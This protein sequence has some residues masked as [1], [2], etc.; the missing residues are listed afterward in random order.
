V[1]ASPP[2]PTAA[3][4]ARSSR[5]SFRALT[6]LTR[7]LSSRHGCAALEDIERRGVAAVLGED[8]TGEGPPE[9]LRGILLPLVPPNG[10]DGVH[11]LAWSFSDRAMWARCGL[12]IFELGAARSPTPS[13]FTS[14]TPCSCGSSPPGGQA[15][16]EGGSIRAA[17]ATLT[18]PIVRVRL[19][20]QSGARALPARLELATGE[21]RDFERLFA[22]AGSAR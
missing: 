11:A 14:S 20:V 6:T 12:S 3:P 10:V 8:G 13:P 21:R 19:R 7:L 9:L 5:S 18:R 22:V 16:D 2:P 15:E 1:S 17:F 4:K